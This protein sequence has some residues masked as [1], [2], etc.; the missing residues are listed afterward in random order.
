MRGWLIKWQLE[1]RITSLVS[2][3][4]GRTVASGF[5]SIPAFFA[6]K[7]YKVAARRVWENVGGRDGGA[8]FN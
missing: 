8:L 7:D 2:C 6:R 1:N 5:N 4:V 3:V